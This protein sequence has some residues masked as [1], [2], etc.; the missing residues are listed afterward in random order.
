[1][2][3]F[4][5]PS[6]V[7]HAN[8]AIGSGRIRAYL[9]SPR[10][11]RDHC[12]GICEEETDA[13]LFGIAAHL[14][15][16]EP[17]AFDKTVAIKPE[18]MSFATTEGKAW[19]AQQ[20]GRLIVK[21]ED[22]NHLRRMHERMPAEVREIF[23]RCR[24]EVTVRTEIDGI[25]VQC[26]PDLWDLDGRRKYDLKTTK[27]IDD[28]ELTVWKRGYHIQDRWYDRV[29]LAETGKRCVESALVFVEHKPPYRWRIVD[30]DPDFRHMGEKAVG[31][32]LH[33]IAA[34]MKSGCWDDEDDVRL[35]ASPPEWAHVP[36]ADTADDEEG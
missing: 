24:R 34:R 7:Y 5:E 10:L 8:A 13:L 2:I 35:L 31:D 26:R 14:R 12:D 22:A 20:A 23:A 25:P 4:D 6:D 32:A 36:D 1:V 27:D 16:L 19:R 9:R 21:E 15:L 18:G 28:V 11:F 3:R 17:E 33:G 30:L 29:I